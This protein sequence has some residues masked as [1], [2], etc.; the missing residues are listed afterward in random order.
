MEKEVCVITGCNSGIGKVLATSMARQGYEVVMLVR[1]SEK[2]AKAFEEI[3]RESKSHVVRL[4]Y[5]DLSS[6][7]SINEVVKRIT[8]RYSRVDVLINN[9]GTFNRKLKQSEDGLEMTLAVNYF[10]VFA[11]TNGLMPLIKRTH[12]ARIVNLGSKVQKYGRILSDT[13]FETEKYNGINAYANSKLL[14]L[15]FTWLLADKLQNTSVTANCVHPGAIHSNIFREY[16]NWIQAILGLFLD[17][18]EDGAEAPLTL[19]TSPRLHGVTGKYFDKTQ[20]NLTAT[21][22]FLKVDSQEIWDQTQRII[23]RIRV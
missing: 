5:V 1:E 9:A 22:Q 14:V 17:T 7:K 20:V 2:S 8:E 3:I 4:E 21:S 11:L 12:N 6:M 15:H 16:P 18:P 13:N 10:A 23:N 19:A